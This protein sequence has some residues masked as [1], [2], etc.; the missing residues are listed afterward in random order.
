[1]TYPHAKVQGQRS[2]SSED[3]VETNGRMDGGECITSNAN[4]VGN[5]VVGNNVVGKLVII[6]YSAHCC[7]TLRVICSAKGRI[8]TQFVYLF[9]L[10]HVCVS[11]RCSCCY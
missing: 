11:E 1:M 6:L 10:L 7:Y 4:A 9:M 3:R 8:G 5:N 2:V